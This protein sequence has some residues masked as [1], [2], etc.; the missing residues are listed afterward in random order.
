MFMWYVGMSWLLLSFVRAQSTTRVGVTISRIP[1]V[2]YFIHSTKWIYS[3]DHSAPA[4]RFGNTEGQTTVSKSIICIKDCTFLAYSLVRI[5]EAIK[6]F[7][8]LLHAS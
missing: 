1:N 8:P 5:T 6:A 4:T 2:R 7:P 3:R